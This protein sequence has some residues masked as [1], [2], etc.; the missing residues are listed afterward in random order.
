[1]VKKGSKVVKKT[2]ITTEIKEHK[3]KSKKTKSSSKKSGK[4]ETDKL[5]IENFISLQKVLTNLAVKLDSLGDQIAKL[6][7]LF[8]ISAK[9]FTEKQGSGMSKEDKEFLEKLNQ[10]MEQ[11]RLIAKGL[12][13]ISEKVNNNTPLNYQQTS[14]RQRPKSMPKI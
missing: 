5:M 3:S 7:S 2:T 14:E 10:L 1:M 11:N 13:M 4:S 8:E 12:T 6:L 9:S